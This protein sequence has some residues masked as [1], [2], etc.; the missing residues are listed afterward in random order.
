MNLKAIRI[1]LICLT[2]P[3]LHCDCDREVRKSI[4]DHFDVTQANKSPVP[5]FPE[6]LDK[7]V[8][9]QNITFST[10]YMELYYT[11]FE[12]DTSIMISKLISGEWTKPKPASFSGTYCDFEPFISP[13]GN[14]LLFASKRPSKGKARMHKDIDIWMV[15]R[16]GLGWS[17]PEILDSLINTYCMEYYPSI[18]SEGNLFFGRNDLALTS[19]DIYFSTLLNGEYSEP[20]KLPETVNLPTTSFN[21]FISPEEDY[22]IFSTYLLEKGA[23]HSDLFISYRDNDLKWLEP[24]NL[25]NDINSPGNDQS[26]WISYD[27]KFL[28]FASNRSVTAGIDKKYKIY[29]ISTSMVEGFDTRKHIP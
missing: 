28:F 6:L 26:P 19:G 8:N 29:W 14:N 10:D 21:A 9:I 20:L 27:G 4:S 22:I 3:G 25:G 12:N 13:D 7:K 1:I 23:W 2:I 24:V 16:D 11:Q 5:F 17:E 15:H 18:S